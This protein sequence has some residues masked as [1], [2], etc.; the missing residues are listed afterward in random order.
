M[1]LR[2]KVNL[3]A[4]ICLITLLCAG[5]YTNADASQKEGHDLI[6]VCAHGCDF[7]R[8][9]DAID[10]EGTRPGAVI[11]ID[12]S[13]HTEG[14]I[15]VAKD[16]KIQGHGVEETIV[17]AA[18]SLEESEERVFAIAKGSMVTIS[19]MTITV[20]R[21]GSRKI[22]IVIRQSTKNEGHRSL[23]IRRSFI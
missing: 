17:Q 14:G 3:P 2:L 6:T 12:D 23:F 8:I 19:Q 15:I 11:R 5:I 21:S 22:N 4:I 1:N 20:L 13:I 9:Q 10:D 18:N 7:A 16:V